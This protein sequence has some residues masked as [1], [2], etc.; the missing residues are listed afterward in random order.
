MIQSAFYVL[1]A[2]STG[3]KSKV[4]LLDYIFNRS[5]GRISIWPG[6][7]NTLL[8]GFEANGIVSEQETGACGSV[9]VL[10]E[11][12]RLTYEAEL[13]SLHTCLDDALDA[14]T[15]ALENAECERTAI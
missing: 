12:G 3:G 11:Y 8:D 6:T 4:E 15:D 2:L 5:H 14:V 7:L 1:M 9:Y 10:T 13:L